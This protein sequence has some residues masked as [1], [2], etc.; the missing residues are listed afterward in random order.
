MC[1]FFGFE[2][3]NMINVRW[4]DNT[5][6]SIVDYENDKFDV[7]LEGDDSHL[8]DELSTIRNQKWWSE[9]IQRFEKKI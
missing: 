2:L 7:V 9:Y 4:Y 3:D 8:G 5:S 6:I 1:Y